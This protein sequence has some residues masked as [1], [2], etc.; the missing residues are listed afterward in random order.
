MG[1]ELCLQRLE[2]WGVHASAANT[3]CANGDSAPSGLGEHL[4]R[5]LG[6]AFLVDLAEV[7]V[8]NKCRLDARNHTPHLAQKLDPVLRGSGEIRDD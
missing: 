5:F 4:D 3:G 1:H 7:G 8:G 6:G 2:R